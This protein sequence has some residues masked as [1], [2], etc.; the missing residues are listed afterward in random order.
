M[1]PHW[2]LAYEQYSHGISSFPDINLTCLNLFIYT[3]CLLSISR[4]MTCCWLIDVLL[5]W[6]NRIGQTWFRSY[7]VFSV[8]Q[9]G[10]RRPSCISKFK[11]LIK[12]SYCA[13]WI[14][15]S[16]Q[17]WSISDK[18]FWSYCNV[19][20]FQSVVG[21]HLGF[22]KISFWPYNSLRGAEMKLEL[23]LDDNWANGFRVIEFLVFFQNSGRRP[24][25][26]SKFK[27]LTIFSYLGCVVD[28]SY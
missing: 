12:C 20:K 23:K 18:Q 14:D 2:S 22:C 11:I 5:K 24:S 3:V 7:W 21:G 26:I 9:S 17:I 27:M 25:W 8:F 19:S 28:D 16:C 4:Q 1:F 15:D 6:R 10:V 13:F